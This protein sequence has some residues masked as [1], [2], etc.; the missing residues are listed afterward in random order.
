MRLIFVGLFIL[1]FLVVPLRQARAQGAA[2]EQSF[3]TVLPDIP[4]MD[5]MTEISNASMSFDKPD[6]RIVHVIAKMNDLNPSRVLSFYDIALYQFGWRK[7]AAHRFI[8]KREEVRIVFEDDSDHGAII[9][10]IL[11][12]H[13]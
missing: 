1:M 6:G 11:L 4:L 7:T 12:P 2:V 10:I 9:R 3:F 5:G 13:L 8:R